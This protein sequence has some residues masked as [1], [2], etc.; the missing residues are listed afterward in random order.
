MATG[1]RKEEYQLIKKS[2]EW[3]LVAAAPLLIKVK[4]K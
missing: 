3:I 2:P 4:L 1:R